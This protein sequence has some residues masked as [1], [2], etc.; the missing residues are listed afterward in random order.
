MYNTNNINEMPMS[1]LLYAFE[2]RMDILLKENAK[3]HP[4]DAEPDWLI[5]I[6]EDQIMPAVE[7][8]NNWEPSDDEIVANN[9][10]G[11]PWHDGCR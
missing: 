11:T 3:M 6:V 8:I 4:M 2:K 9:S 1:R 5:E 10:C 7:Y